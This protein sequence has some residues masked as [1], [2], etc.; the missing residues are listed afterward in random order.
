MDAGTSEVGDV[1]LAVAPEID[2]CVHGDSGRRTVGRVRRRVV[3]DADHRSGGEH[4]H[5]RIERNRGCHADADS[6]VGCRAIEVD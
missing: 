5:I 1:I 2:P 3:V 6:I 4:Q